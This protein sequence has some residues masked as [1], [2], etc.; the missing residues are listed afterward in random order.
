MKNKCFP[1]VLRLL[2]LGLLCPGLLCLTLLTLNGCSSKVPEDPA[3]ERLHQAI[4]ALAT[5]CNL[6]LFTMF[7]KADE[8]YANANIEAYFSVSFILEVDVLDAQGKS[9][10]KISRKGNGSRRWRRKFAVKKEGKSI[11]SIAITYCF[12]KNWALVNDPDILFI[13][14]VIPE[15]LVWHLDEEPDSYQAKITLSFL[16]NLLNYPRI[17][18]VWIEYNNE[19]L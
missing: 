15:V 4:E 12:Q 13:G 6:P 3:I 19:K 17:E 11:G 5:T 9:L 2:C 1:L 10:L 18:Y 16:K 7:G 8:E 14:K